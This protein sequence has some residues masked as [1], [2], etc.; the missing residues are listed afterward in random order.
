MAATPLGVDPEGLRSAAA[1]GE[2][3]SAGLATPISTGSVGGDV[4]TAAA[5]QAVSALIEAVRADQAAYLSG[6]ATL[7]ASGANGY[8]STDTRSA[9]Q[10]DGLR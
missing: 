3:L 5:V 10:I 9:G 4:P 7:L 8:E 2:E 1:S 6:R